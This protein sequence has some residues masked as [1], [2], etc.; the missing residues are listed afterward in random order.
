MTEATPVTEEVPAAA[1]PPVDPGDVK[2]EIPPELQPRFNQIWKNFK[3]QEAINARL[4]QH[5]SRMEGAL[6]AALDK[7]SRT[8]REGVEAKIRDAHDR[9]DTQAAMTLTREAID[10]AAKPVPKVATQEAPQAE[11]GLAPQEMTVLF[12]WAN[13]TADDGSV[14]RP[15]AQ[16]GHPK[17]RA[18]AAMAQAVML[19]PD[20][21]DKPL[22]AVLAE[23]DRRMGLTAPRANGNGG[24]PGGIT[25]DTR[26]RAPAKGGAALLSPAEIAQARKMGR[27]P[28]QYARSKELLVKAG[29]W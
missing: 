16:Q 21:A 19:D 12:A 29:K 13:E 10:A 3:Q 5:L 8:E 26:P 20:F 14:K 23:V 25:S 18:T 4:N 7:L 6:D 27:T 9:G 17:Q 22:R 1:A 28:E 11:G 2:V 15:W 24:V